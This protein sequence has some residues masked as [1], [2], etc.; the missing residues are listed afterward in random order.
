MTKGELVVDN[1]VIA[2]SAPRLCQVAGLLEVVD[3]LSGSAFSDADGLRDVSET[4]TGIDREA[5]EHV[6]VVG[7]EDPRM[8]VIT[9]NGMGPGGWLGTSPSAGFG[10]LLCRLWDVASDQACA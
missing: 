6:R 4:R 1:I 8:V 5:Y 3:Q 9:G 7:D 2:A 10:A